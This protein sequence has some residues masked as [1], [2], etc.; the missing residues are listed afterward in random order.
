[1]KIDITHEPP[2]DIFL[3]RGKYLWSFIILLILGG[4]GV[5]LGVYTIFSDTMYYENLETASLAIL[6]G[7][8]V[9]ISYMGE[10]LQAYKSLTLDQKKELAD[11]VRTHPEIEVYCALVTKAG[12]QPIRAEY[13]VCQNWAEDENRKT[14][15]KNL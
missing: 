2:A 7:A 6:V 1:M 14:S 4:G 3:N 12:R 8:A 13:E 10:K 15:P 9:L 11:M 5:L